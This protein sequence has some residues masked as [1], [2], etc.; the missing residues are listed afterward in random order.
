MK[1]IHK[2]DQC[3]TCKVTIEFPRCIT[4]KKPLHDD[5]ACRSTCIFCEEF[6]CEEDK[7]QHDKDNNCK[8][9]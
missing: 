2:M 8:Q 3:G 5:Y 6:F 9:L 1:V 4:C 7:L